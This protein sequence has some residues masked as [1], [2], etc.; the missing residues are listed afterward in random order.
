LTV[1]GAGT[2]EPNGGGLIECVATTEPDSVTKTE[3]LAGTT[4]STGTTEPDVIVS[5]DLFDAGSSTVWYVMKE[6]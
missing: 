4:K 2:R 1:G 3:L 6:M 5:S